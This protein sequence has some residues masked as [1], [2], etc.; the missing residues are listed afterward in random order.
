MHAILGSTDH[1]HLDSF[2]CSCF[3]FA[4]FLCTPERTEPCARPP[5]ALDA[6]DRS[7]GA[8]LDAVLADLKS[9]SPTLPASAAP[10]TGHPFFYFLAGREGTHPR[11]G[12]RT[13]HRL[14][15]CAHILPIPGRS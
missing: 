12:R 5:L 10:P 9:P 3:F 8:S 4:E 7:M 11:T 2:D 14:C 15:L 1:M 13:G 6:D